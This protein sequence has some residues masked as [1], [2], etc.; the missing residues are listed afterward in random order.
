M[1][2]RVRACLAPRGPQEARACAIPTARALSLKAEARAL[3]NANETYAEAADDVAT[4]QQ[5]PRRAS[6]YK[7][8]IAKKYQAKYAQSKRRGAR[9]APFTAQKIAQTFRGP[10]FRRRRFRALAPPSTRQRAGSSGAASARARVF[11]WARA[12]GRRRARA[13]ANASRGCGIRARAAATNATVRARGAAGGGGAGGAARP[14]T[15]RPGGAASHTPRRGPRPI[16]LPR[17]RAAR[18]A[19][20]GP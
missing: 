5:Q 7:K 20:R 3:R 4:K 18:R 13:R 10:E 14:D 12:G 15:A 2:L 8:K 19:P 16:R 11:R 17:S 1:T 6:S 9:S